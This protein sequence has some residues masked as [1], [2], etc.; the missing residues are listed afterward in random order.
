LQAALRSRGKFSGFLPGVPHFE[1]KR[2][3]YVRGSAAKLARDGVAKT[4]ER[5]GFETCVTGFCTR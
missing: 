5:I 3:R 1:R 2:R 4:I